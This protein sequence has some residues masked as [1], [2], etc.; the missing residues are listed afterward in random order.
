LRVFSNRFVKCEVAVSFSDNVAVGN[1][2]SA[3][4]GTCTC[5]RLNECAACLT[6]SAQG[7]VGLCRCISACP[8]VCSSWM[9]RL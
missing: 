2:A 4:H 7:T 3:V 6:H 1:G 5:C 8:R 9:C